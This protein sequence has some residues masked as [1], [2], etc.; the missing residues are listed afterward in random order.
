MLLWVVVGVALWL[1]VVVAVRELVVAGVLRR[2]RRELLAE[3]LPSALTG[4]ADEE[5][6][7]RPEPAL[8]WVSATNLPVNGRPP[9]SSTRPRVAEPA[10][11]E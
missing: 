8:F 10:R 6:V 3:A 5:S 1:A 7:A 9:E 11:A 2:L 4:A